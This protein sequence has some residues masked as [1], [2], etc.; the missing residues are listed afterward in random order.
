MTDWTPL[1]KCVAC[2]GNDLW[3]FA[4]FGLQQL[5]NNFHEWGEVSGEEYPIRLNLCRTCGHSQQSGYVDPKLIFDKYPYVSGTSQTLR[6][7]FDWFVSKVESDMP[8]RRLSILEI[9]SNDGTLL[10]KFAARGHFCQGVEPAQNIYSPATTYRGYWDEKALAT[11]AAEFDVLIAM[12][13]LAHVADPAEFLRLCKKVL[14]PDGRLYVQVSQSRM[15]ETGEFDTAYSEHIS[16]FEDSSFLALARLVGLNPRLIH[17]R[18]IHGGSKIVEFIHGEPNVGEETERDMRRMVLDRPYDKFQ[19]RAEQ[20]VRALQEQIN[21]YRLMGYRIVGV[22]AAAKAMTVLNFGKIRLDY[23]VDE[24]PL[25][26]GKYSPGMNIPIAPFDAL[27]RE[28]EKCLFVF[29]AWNFADEL[30]RKLVTLRRIGPSDDRVR[31]PR[32]GDV[33]YCYFPE[34]RRWQIGL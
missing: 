3:Q 8:S 24:N 20:T 6:D 32:R 13:V 7:H 29:T 12:N 16:F 1:D 22:G 30:A 25:K 26:I 17:V 19:E 9:A 2:G 23:I 33:G 11:V 18:E 27:K 14:R 31:G 15:I 28:P 4:D 10:Q 34:P 21:N 5:A